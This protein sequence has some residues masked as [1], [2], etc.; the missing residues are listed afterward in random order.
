MEYNNFIS[1]IESFNFENPAEICEKILNYD[2]E[3]LKLFIDKIDDKQCI[4]MLH[5]LCYL[6]DD[7][8]GVLMSYIF[9]NH[10][11]MINIQYVMIDES[12]RYLETITVINF[13][14]NI[15]INE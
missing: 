10:K 1:I 4:I 3:T 11:N 13:A 9:E 2:I 14:K 6:Y 12:C 7:K 15:M 5:C 8:N